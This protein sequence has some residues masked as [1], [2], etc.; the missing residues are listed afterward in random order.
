MGLHLCEPPAPR[1]YT[2]ADIDASEDARHDELV[3]AI[4]SWPPRRVPEP[5]TTELHDAAP[6]VLRYPRMAR[7][8]EPNA[9]GI[10]Q[11]IDLDESRSVSM[12]PDLLIALLAVLT[13]A[14]AA[15][16]VI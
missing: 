11:P 6:T 2:Q 16:G 13:L 5:I 4:L 12:I 9:L 10:E 15:S 14:L 1:R 8:P 7:R 3:A